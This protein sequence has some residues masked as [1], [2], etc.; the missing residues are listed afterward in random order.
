MTEEYTDGRWIIAW[1][2]DGTKWSNPYFRDESLKNQFTFENIDESYSLTSEEQIDEGQLVVKLF[3]NGELKISGS[4]VI[5]RDG[6]YDSITR[7]G[8]PWFGYYQSTF[9]GGDY[10]RN[11]D[12]EEYLENNILSIIICEGIT[13][14]TDQLTFQ[15]IKASS[16]SLPSTLTEVNNKAFCN[17]KWLLDLANNRIWICLSRNKLV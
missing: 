2:F 16:V 17:S 9:Y 15:R 4:G 5:K 11:D 14:I 1:R 12:F 8:T 10:H 7:G 6:G 3:S 13:G